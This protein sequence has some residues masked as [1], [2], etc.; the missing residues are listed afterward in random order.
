MKKRRRGKSKKAKLELE[1]YTQFNG[2]NFFN[3]IPMLVVTAFSMS[4]S[5]LRVATLGLDFINK[6]KKFFKTQSRS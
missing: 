3:Q 6:F 4:W 2:I 5:R 1:Y